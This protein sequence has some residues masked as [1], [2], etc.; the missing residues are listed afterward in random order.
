MKEKI[1][2]YIFDIFPKKQF[3]SY[4]IGANHIP[5]KMI[6]YEKGQNIKINK[7]YPGF[8]VIREFLYR[9]IICGFMLYWINITY[10]KKWILYI[11][12][13]LL[14][15]DY[16]LVMPTMA[17][18]I[19]LEF[20]IFDKYIST[21]LKKRLH[22]VGFDKRK[23]QRQPR[24]IYSPGLY[25]MIIFF[26]MSLSIIEMKKVWIIY[27]FLLLFT[28][29]YVIIMQEKIEKKNIISFYS[30][31]DDDDSKDSID[32]EKD[33][34]IILNNNEIIQVNLLKT[35][36]FVKN[37]DDI[38]LLYQDQKTQTLERES[39]VYIKIKNTKVR[40]VN[41]KWVNGDIIYYDI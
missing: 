25:E 12:K 29:L 19:I 38:L 7:N 13:I 9:I 28:L 14:K 27:V 21:A 20:F 1:F 8:N 10:V 40:Y 15:E 35:L 33:I 31:V 6:G 26:T 39:I 41:N 30:K 18:I 34:S 5:K 2:E 3:F 24:Y 11:W 36:I 16:P 32:I 23:E 4:V 37:N 17:I 22:E